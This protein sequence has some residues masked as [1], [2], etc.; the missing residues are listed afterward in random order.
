MVR[1]YIK[2]NSEVKMKLE[3]AIELGNT[4]KEGWPLSNGEEY[5]KALELLIKAGER[6]IF[7]RE[8]PSFVIVGQLPSETGGKAYA[9]L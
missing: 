3:E 2:G 7:N 9:N 4:A 1:G 5:Y 8:N 6:E